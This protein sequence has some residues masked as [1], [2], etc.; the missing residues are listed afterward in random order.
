MNRGPFGKLVLRKGTV[1]PALVL[2]CFAGRAA[3]QLTV[4][5]VDDNGVPITNGFRWTLE[6]DNS[7]G[8]K[9]TALDGPWAGPAGGT[10]QYPGTPS[11]NAPYVPGGV[12]ES[13]TLSVN[14][15]HSH[16]IVACTGDTA[17][18]MPDPAL[19]PQGYAGAPSSVTISA[20]NC[21]AYVP[22]KNYMVSVLPWHS[23]A[24]G[25]PANAQTGWSMSGRNV[26]AGQ[27]TTTVVVH[28]FPQPTGQITALVFEDNQSINGAYDQ[29]DEHGLS[30]FKYIIADPAG[31]MLQN[32]FA[33]PIGTT[34]LYQCSNSVN[35]GGAIV[36]QPIDCGTGLPVVQ[37]H[38]PQFQYDPV[39]NL[40]V[41][42]FVGD[43]NVYS[44]PG[45][46]NFAA[47]TPYQLANCIDPYTLAP[48]GI[49]EAVVRY[50]PQN[51]YTLEPVPP[52]NGVP[53]GD[54]ANSSACADMLL[55]A[56][57]EGTRGND[58]WIR[59]GEPRY[60]I[61]LGQLNW[62]VFYG[63]VHPMN[64]LSKLPGPKTGTIQGQVVYT[65]D[66]H[67]P[68]SAGL[69]SPGPPVPN[70]YV[71]LNNLSGS[72]EQV[73]TA[74]CDPVTGKFQITGVPPGTYQIAVWDKPINMIID[75]RTVTVT[76]GATV[77]LGYTNPSDA[78]AVFGWFG[79][80]T[81]SVFYDANGDGHRD[82]PIG[83]PGI[84]ATP[85]NVRYTDGSFWERR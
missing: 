44:C 71:G 79:T 23:S 66:S 24:A 59:A 73:Y 18:P 62:L 76:A 58:A 45:G 56:T 60:N 81:G 28:A 35:V 36:K 4:N 49:G 75:Y 34:Y 7:Y 11:P 69:L 40:P 85:V 16:A 80:L 46:T 70:A 39:T 48:M 55:T 51:K 3:A 26:A 65:H 84:P 12:N 43:G 30:N 57:L 41:R 25:T 31:P 27:L 14:V 29:P 61:S 47:Y 33:D 10:I 68:L 37:G 22:T 20:A 9:K 1:L 83:E 74:A 19:L 72:D 15:H 32:A 52:A 53:C 17:L 5:V 77:D 6:E 42:D 21:P 13:Y 78:I 54:T 64:G 82:S 38:Q 67:P 63:F 50:L 2:L 8:V